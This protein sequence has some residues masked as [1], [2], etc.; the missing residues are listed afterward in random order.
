LKFLASLFS[1][2]GFF[3]L[4]M[5]KH[6]KFVVLDS[7]LTFILPL[8]KQCS[9]ATKF[10]EHIWSQHLWTE[11]RANR[12]FWYLPIFQSSVWSSRSW[13]TECHVCLFSYLIESKE[14]T[15]RPQT[16]KIRRRKKIEREIIV[17][18]YYLGKNLWLA[19][20]WWPSIH[21]NLKKG[22]VNI[23]L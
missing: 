17:L 5:C 15:S 4:W 2:E 23:F 21:N 22:L 8:R 16:P 19:I 10:S 12:F 14:G 7:P 20:V 18:L 6:Q 1:S 11:W 9:L 13:L 3:L